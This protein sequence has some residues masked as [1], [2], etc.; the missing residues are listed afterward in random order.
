MLFDNKTAIGVVVVPHEAHQPQ[1]ALSQQP[2]K[3]FKARKLVVVAS[4]ALGTPQILERSGVGNKSLLEK[5]DIPVVAA[6]PGVGDAYQDHH[7]CLYPY[8]TSLK[9]EET[10]DALLGGR[11]D[12]SQAVKE[13][14][15]MLGWNSIDLASKLRPTDA[16]VVA[17][18]KEFKGAWDRDYGSSPTRPLMLMGVV[19][20]FLGDP[21]LVPVGQYITAGC[22]T[23][24]PYSRG[25]IHITSKDANS[26][27]DFETGFLNDK[28]DLDLKAQVWAY[29][30]QREIVRRLSTYRGELDMGHPKFAS[31][32]AAALVSYDDVDGLDPA[33]TAERIK[34][35]PLEY[36]AAD[37]AAIENC[38]RENLNTTWHSLGTCAMRDVKD[39]GVVDKNLNVHGVRGLKLCDLSV[40][41][42]NVGAN[43]NNTAL[44]VGEKAAEIVIRELGLAA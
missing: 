25:S 18:G 5:L 22:Y 4:G 30:R 21:S 35:P 6:L 34:L 7:L 24:Y 9:P 15:P 40:I 33:S 29:K 26:A 31:N 42:E 19:A 16:E 36:T 8:K 32:S 37:D 27:P 39:G 10:N 28:D 1:T 23:A 20:S 38:I 44:L 12:F 2:A 17:L 11:V 41:P 14:N 13:K 3:S 43:T